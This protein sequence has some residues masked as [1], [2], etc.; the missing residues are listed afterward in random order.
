MEVSYLIHPAYFPLHFMDASKSPHGGP[1]HFR[2]LRF[3][4]RDDAKRQST[5]LEGA[6]WMG[7]GEYASNWSMVLR[8][9]MRR[10]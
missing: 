9:P 10:F 1:Q 5:Y 2:K 7:N 3:S 8:N 6:R 4:C